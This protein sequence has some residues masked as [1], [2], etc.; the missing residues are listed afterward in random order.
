VVALGNRA[1]H[2]LSGG[3]LGSTEAALAAPRGRVLEL[4]TAAH[5]RAYRW[6]NGLVG[7][8]LAGLPMLLLTTTGRKTG[9]ERT[10]PLPYF[11]HP[12]GVM[13]VASFAGGPKNP[14]WYENL[15]AKPEVSVQIRG[16]KYSARAT[17]ATADER[18]R[19]WPEIVTAS[20]N[21]ADYARVAPREIPVVV[22]REASR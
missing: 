3:R 19:L 5:L 12:D 10:V 18:A 16:R 17:T 15:A 9:L 4:I 22:L 1:L 13:I 6:T 7:A 8:E 21:Y 20:P 2:R 14:A 11:P